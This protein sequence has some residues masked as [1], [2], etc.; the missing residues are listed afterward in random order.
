[1]KKNNLPAFSGGK[2]AFSKPIAITKPT[3][4]ATKRIMSRYREVFNSGIITNA[5]Y[6]KEFEANV[7]EYVGVK[8]V[9]CVS[10][11]TCGLML[12]L[13]SLNLKGEVIIPSFTFHATAHAV[14]WNN[15]TPVFVDCDKE[16]FNIS[17]SDVEKAIN[18]NTAAI[19]ATHVFGNPANI[20]ALENVAKKNGLPLIFDAAHGFGSRYK[21]KPIG[22]FGTAEV[23]SLSPTKLLTSAE[24]GIIATNNDEL[25]KKL[26]VAR[27]YGDNG[28]Y[29]CEFSGFNSRMSE[30]NAILGIESLKDLNKNVLRRKKMVELY[31]KELKN[32]PGISF[33]KIEQGNQSSYKDFSIIVDEKEFGIDRDLLAEYLI[34][35]NIV[36]KKYFYPPVHKQKAFQS[37]AVY[38]KNSSF[39]NTD[40]ISK[41][42]LSVPLFSHISEREVEKVCFSVTRI[43]KNIV[44]AG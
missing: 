12:V 3:I 27:N 20:V 24:G 42:A 41:R 21:G 14:V 40:F 1:M 2:P 22:G 44:K 7:A 4:P 30:L 15:L 10:S 26:R 19:L 16:T 23:F 32:I 37:Y 29:D 34:K 38:S 9:I 17:V 18:K 43:Y 11:C 31:K 39:V 25:A 13:K 6:V 36:V 8:N 28:S 35:E 33:Q 5:K